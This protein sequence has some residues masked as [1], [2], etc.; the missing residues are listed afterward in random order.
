MFDAHLGLRELTVR[1]WISRTRMVAARRL[2]EVKHWFGIATWTPLKDGRHCVVCGYSEKTA[3]N[4]S[5]K[6]GR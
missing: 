3:P 5:K 6:E 1:G 2:A 4:N